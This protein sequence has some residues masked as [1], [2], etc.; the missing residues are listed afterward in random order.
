MTFSRFLPQL[1]LDFLAS[2]FCWYGATLL[3]VTIKHSVVKTYLWP[4]E[5]HNCC[6]FALRGSGCFW[7]WTVLFAG[8]GPWRSNQHM[9]LDSPPPPRAW[10]AVFGLPPQHALQTCFASYKAPWKAASTHTNPCV[11]EVRGLR[12]RRVPV[13]VED[14]QLA[15]DLKMYPRLMVM[16]GETEM[17]TAHPAAWQGGAEHVFLP[18]PGPGHPASSFHPVPLLPPAR[19]SFL[20]PPRSRTSSQREASYPSNISFSLEQ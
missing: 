18:D 2:T 9:E 1:E 7:F 20:A 11:C 5:L 14:A 12:L 13:Q 8:F 4:H 10:L 6:L 17:T 3:L 15:A 16:I 19:T